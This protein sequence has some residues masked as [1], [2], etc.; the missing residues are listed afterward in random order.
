[1]V[2]VNCDLELYSLRDLD[3]LVDTGDE[4]ELSQVDG[5]HINEKMKP[6][7]VRSKTLVE[8]WHERVV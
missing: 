6:A 2:Q 5:Q 3:V 1:M 7:K 4:G 8:W